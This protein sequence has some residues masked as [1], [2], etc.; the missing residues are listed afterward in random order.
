MTTDEFNKTVEDLTDKIKA[1]LVRKQGEYNLDEDRL[2]FF[3]KACVLMGERP[4]QTLLGYTNKQIVSEF[5]MGA[6]D[7]AFTEER[8]LEKILDIVCYQYLLYAVLKDT[9][10]FKKQAGGR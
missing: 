10:A 8:W 6:S 4:H 7:D 3:K 9:K 1:I 5:E 2:S